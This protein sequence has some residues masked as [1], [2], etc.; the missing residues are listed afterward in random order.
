VI[1]YR[2]YSEIPIED[3]AAPTITQIT[4]DEAVKMRLRLILQLIQNVETVEKKKSKY[5]KIV[6]IV[7]CK[8]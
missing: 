2:I 3:L 1:L 6:E 8:Y 5:I 4:M 7:Y